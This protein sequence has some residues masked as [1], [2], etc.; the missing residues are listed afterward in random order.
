MEILNSVKPEHFFS[1]FWDPEADSF[2]RKLKPDEHVHL[3]KRELQQKSQTDHKLRLLVFSLTLVFLLWNIFEGIYYTV[4]NL[5]S[6]RV[7]NGIHYFNYLVVSDT[8][9]FSHQSHMCC[10]FI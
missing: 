10:Y 8:I 6:F 4:K 3:L 2:N 1:L 9:N 7:Y 5:V